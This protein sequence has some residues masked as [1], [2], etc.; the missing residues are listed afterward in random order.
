[1]M[2]CCW[3]A[4]AS[5]KLRK[6]SMKRMSVFVY[7]LCPVSPIAGMDAASLSGFHNSLSCLLLLIVLLALLILLQSD[8]SPAMMLIIASPHGL[9]I[10]L[11]LA[12]WVIAMKSVI[13]ARLPATCGPFI[14]KLAR[15]VV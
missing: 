5:T 13:M 11:K 1:M 9:L 15:R 4:R 7:A 3:V 14:T 2:M 8:A 6:N 12:C 10:A